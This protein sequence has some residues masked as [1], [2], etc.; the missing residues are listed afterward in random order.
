MNLN[1]HQDHPGGFTVTFQGPLLGG[2]D[3][4]LFIFDVAGAPDLAASAGVVRRRADVGVGAPDELSLRL[5]Q[6]IEMREGSACCF[7][8][9]LFH[10]TAPVIQGAKQR[11]VNPGARAGERG[12]AERGGGSGRRSSCLVIPD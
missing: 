11:E 10:S 4:R 8:A 2:A 9:D 12:S 1:V 3:S 5:A 7:D 6:A